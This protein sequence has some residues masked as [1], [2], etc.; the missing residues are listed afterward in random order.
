MGSYSNA[1]IVANYSAANLSHTVT[2][3]TSPPG[4]ALVTGAGVYSNGQTATFTAPLEV[5]NPPNYY[6][7]SQF[8]LSNTV[9]PSQV[10]SS[11][12]G[13]ASPPAGLVAWWPG[14]GNADDIVGGNN[15]TLT[16]GAGFINGEVG[17]AFNFNADHEW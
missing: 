10:G 9:I 7:F 4:L 6:Y 11:A 15:G 12:Q 8:T 16:N 14:N 17:Q 1:L 2:T 3:A 13:C 5:T